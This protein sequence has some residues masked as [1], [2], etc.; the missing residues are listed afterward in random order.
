MIVDLSDAHWTFT[1]AGTGSSVR[2]VIDADG[3][4]FV[5]TF[6]EAGSQAFERFVES[7]PRTGPVD[8]AAEATRVLGENPFT[9]EPRYRISWYRRLFRRPSA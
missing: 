7:L 9:E 2:V 8:L 3:R 5:A 6:D 1:P 4:R